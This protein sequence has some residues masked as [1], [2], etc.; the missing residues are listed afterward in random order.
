MSNVIFVIY[1][2]Y[3]YGHGHLILIQALLV[4]LDTAPH[5]LRANNT[6]VMFISVSKTCLFLAL[7]AQVHSAVKR[8]K[9]YVELHSCD[10]SG[11]A[12]EIASY[13]TVVKEILDYVTAGP[14]KGK[15]Y[16]E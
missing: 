1:V 13:D 15:T 10:N 7:I 2:H 16:D 3:I 8:K 11:I 14:F 4:G 6:I 12:D 9:T 5:A